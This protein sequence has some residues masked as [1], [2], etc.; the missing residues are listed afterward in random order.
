MKK[1]FTLLFF[2]GIFITS[3]KAQSLNNT[4]WR[5]Y[6]NSRPNPV[7]YM[8]LN[9]TLYYQP[10]AGAF[11]PTSIYQE[12]GNQYQVS[13]VPGLNCV[14]D[15]GKYTF[16]FVPNAV[17]FT[18]VSDSCSP[19]VPFYNNSI[20]L[21]ISTEIDDAT[22]PNNK[23]DLFPNPAKSSFVVKQTI[24]TAAK[25]YSIHSLEGK[26]VLEGEL[27]QAEER[28]QISQLKAGIYFFII[29]GKVRKFI[30]L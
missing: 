13:G 12:N 17:I 29:E 24:F 18:L 20:W 10:P 8:F 2:A 16:Q 23:L 19:R 25:Y 26:R 14:T 7:I 1:I 22:P 30:K 28:I 15:T 3:L 11:V 4:T 5:V 27:T 6:V 21:D 9:D